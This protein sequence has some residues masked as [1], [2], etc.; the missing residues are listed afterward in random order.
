MTGIGSA[1]SSA[2]PERPTRR[3]AVLLDTNAVLLP[4][5][6]HF[7]LEAEIERLV[8]P[9]RIEIPYSV[10]R[11]L[12]ALAARGVRG[13][14]PS[15]EWTRRFPRRATRGH[16]DDALVQAARP[17]RDWVVT[18]DRELQQ[19][20]TARGVSTLIPRDRHRLEPIRGDLTSGRSRRKRASAAMVKNGA[21][22][23]SS[24]REAR[25]KE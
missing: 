19:R 17:S 13:A 18:A 15:L 25:A 20:L 12:E 8:G 7:P 16:G 11:E 10:V 1:S 5:A 6:R 9:S 23:V 14:Q 21:P 4:F 2:A 24:S 22:V 3:P